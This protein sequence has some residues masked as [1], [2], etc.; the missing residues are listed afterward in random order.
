MLPGAFGKSVVEGQRH[1]IEADIGRALDVVVTTENICAGS[2][3]A[4]V[5]GEQEGNAARPHVG[6]ADRVL[7]LA[8]APDQRRGLLRG[9]H[10]G[11]ALKLRAGHTA[12]AFDL[13]R[14]PLL[15]LLANVVKAID[16][17]PDELLVL[18]AILEDVPHHAVKHGNIGAGT[19][20]YIVGRVRGGARQARIDDDEIGPVQLLA[21]E[22]MLQGYRMSLRRIA[23]HDHERLRIPDI[24]EAVGHRAVAPG[25]GH[26]GDSRRMADTRLM[27]GVVGAPERAELAEQIRGFVGHLGRTEPIDGIA[28]RLLANLEQLVADLVH[29]RIP[30]DAR[31]LPVDELHRIAKPTLTMDQLAHRSALGT[32]RAAVDRRI[33]TR[34]LPDPDPIKH[35]GGHRASDGAMRADALADG[36]AGCERPSGRGLRLA[37]APDRQR[38][39]R[40]QAA[41]GKA[42]PAQECAAVKP[43]GLSGQSGCD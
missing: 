33:P 37:D 38:A 12:D 30:G 21:L 3:L 5:S 1:D 18:P 10:L 11:N 26:A 40:G 25:V 31:P 6:G 14:R 23:A 22:Q 24:I 9:E 41:T 15:D 27:V 32:M 42:G 36:R 13:V 29:R 16:A 17:L 34:L 28:A 7:G 2:G 19:K 8:H 43:A 35:F 20:A 39:Q 4:D